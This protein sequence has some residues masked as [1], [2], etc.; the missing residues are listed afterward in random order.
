MKRG[1]TV[2]FTGLSGSGKT[3]S[4]RALERWL[5]SCGV[6]VE[7]LDGDEIRQSISQD[8][9]YDRRD[10]QQHIERLGFICKLLSRN[11]I[12]VLVAA[13]SPYREARNT[14]RNLVG[15]FVEVYMECPL[16]LLIEY[17]KKGLY[18]KALAGEIPNFSGI[19]DPYEAPVCADVTIH[20]YRDTVEEGLT[21]IIDKLRT[22]NLL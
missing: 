5:R 17:D 8:L 9:G 16:E 6:R 7:V 2:W 13:I 18:R 4:S 12:A 22:L 3:T 20:T 19:S 14:V 1:Y 15:D 11:G 21:R 10:R